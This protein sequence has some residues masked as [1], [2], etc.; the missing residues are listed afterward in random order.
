[1][2]PV[3]GHQPSGAS[4]LEATITSP[5]SEGLTIAASATPHT[6]GTWGELIASTASDAYGVTVVVAGTGTTASVNARCLV[7]IGMGAGGSEIVLIPSL[8]AGNIATIASASG[9]GAVYHFPIYIRAGARLAARCQALI[10]SETVTV[11]VYLHQRPIGQE[12]WCGSRVTAYGANS[13]TSSGVAHTPG[14]TS[15]YATATEI[16]ASTA[17][18]IRAMQIGMDL[19]TDTTG[20]SLRGMVRVGVGATPDYVAS[21]LPW[22]ESTTV[23]TVDF[24]IANMILSQLRFNIPAATRLAVSAAVSGTGES[25]G[26]IVYGVD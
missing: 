3:V 10:A 13:A 7:D 20:A 5:S 22:K 16:A 1:M 19:G 8:M 24:N 25:R 18:R 4:F 11:M 12:F 2:S 14:S 15:A 23:E 17:N 9:N 21:H 26:W 6:L